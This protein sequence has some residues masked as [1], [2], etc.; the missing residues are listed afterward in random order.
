MRVTSR[1]RFRYPSRDATSTGSVKRRG[2]PESNPG[3]AGAGVP[4]GSDPRGASVIVSSAPTMAFNPT[5]FA[6]R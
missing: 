5:R 3:P 2:S 1:H 6:A 4:P